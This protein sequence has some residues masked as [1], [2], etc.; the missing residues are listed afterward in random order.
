M[1]RTRNAAYGQP[2]RGFD[3]LPLRQFPLKSLRKLP[4]FR[5]PRPDIAAAGQF[6]GCYRPAR[7]A[8]VFFKDAPEVASDM[9][10]AARVIRK[11]I[12]EIRA[13]HARNT[14]LLLG[15]TLD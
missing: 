5:S 10:V 9:R 7:G 6:F 12:G 11:L 1:H 8:S 14:E 3:S 4:I 2:Y 13:S 15:L